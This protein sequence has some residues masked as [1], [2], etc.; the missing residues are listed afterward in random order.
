MSAG[1]FMFVLPFLPHLEANMSTTEELWWLACRPPEN[2][3]VTAGERADNHS[4]P[5]AD[6]IKTLPSVTM[7]LTKRN[8]E[9]TS[10]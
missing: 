4:R 5:A 3:V 6:G 2:I 9:S 1:D 10:L 7:L 8:I